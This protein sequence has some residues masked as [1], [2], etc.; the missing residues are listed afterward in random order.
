[1]CKVLGLAVWIIHIMGLDPDGFFR[2]S[3]VP[4]QNG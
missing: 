1:M 2:V 4:L 3:R